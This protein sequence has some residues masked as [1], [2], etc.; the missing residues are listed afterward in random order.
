MAIPLKYNIR[1]LLVRRVSTAMTAGGIALV[2]AVFVIVMGMVAGLGSAISDT[3]SPDNVVVVRKGSTT[4]TSSAVQL[5]Q[6]DALK[7][8]P[9]IKRDADGNPLASPELPVQVLMQRS[10]GASDNVVVRGVLPVALQV[11]Q[12]VHLIEGRM[13]KPALNEVIVGKAL[14]GRYANTGV[15]S[16]MHFGRGNWRVVGIFDAG[17][18]SFESEVWADIHNVQD[19]TQR[20]AYYACARLKMLAGTD[21]DA[22]IRRIADDPRI[23]LQAQTETDYYKD[24]SVVANQLR[25]LGMIVAIIMGIGA[26]FAA[27]NTMYAAVSARTTEIGT[28]RALGFR[29]GAVL[30]SFLLESLALAVAAGVL[31]VILALPINGFSTSFGNFVTFSTMAFAFR[32][33]PAVMLQALL[34]AAVMGVLG[35]WL[36]ARQAMKMQVVEALRKG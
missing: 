20:G 28:L 23:N 26:V 10:G 27:M 11:H 31:G 30:G 12:N 3:G 18:S 22:L 16:T 8:L 29:P 35:G 17:G 13:F 15:G 1:S 25:A 32:V 24:Q 6:F 7:F 4:E 19:D 5:D 36:P 2:V 14:V 34:F 21:V 9:Q 33:T